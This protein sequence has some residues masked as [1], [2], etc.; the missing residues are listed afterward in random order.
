MILWVC[1][2]VSS[3]PQIALSLT[4]PILGDDPVYHS[5]LTLARFGIELAACAKG[6]MLPYP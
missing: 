1:R 2:I 3:A 5:G 4:S 6:S